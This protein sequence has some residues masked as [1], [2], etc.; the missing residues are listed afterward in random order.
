MRPFASLTLV[1]ALAVAATT[2]A[3]PQAVAQQVQIEEWEV[4]Y[5]ESRPRDPYVAPDG[6]VWFV[7]QAG[8]YAAVLDPATG[9]FS[10]HDLPDQA[11]P[12]NLIVDDQGDI[13]YAG[14]RAA[15]IGHL[16]PE[17]GEIH[18]IAMP[19][20][21]PRDPHTL[22]HDGRGGIFF[23]AQ[24]ANK[25]GHLDPATGALR[26]VEAPRVE[27]RGGQMV[28]VRPYGIKVDS[29]GTAWVALLGANLIASVDPSDMSMETYELPEDARPR[30]LVVDSSDRIWYVDWER[31]TLARL[32]PETREVTEWESPGGRES[33]PY[34]MAIDPDDRIWYVETGTDRNPFVGFDPA[35]EE[36]TQTPIPSGAGAVRHMHYDARTN[37]IWF[38]TD[39]NT[40]GQARLPPLTGRVVS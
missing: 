26:F 6:R 37:S 35:T 38:G 3:P 11:G 18:Q 9:E 5:P 34:A 31:G 22:V 30:R 1:G 19:D 23:T 17:S 2:I 4:P 21:D 36:F 24:G 13:W 15:H 39:N 25:I 28:G 16:D 40:I 32:V 29:E 7:G 33:G 8:H 27:G 12:H 14:N 10:K 20:G